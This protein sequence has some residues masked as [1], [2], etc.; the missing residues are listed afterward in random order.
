LD[1]GWEQA[2]TPGALSLI[3][4]NRIRIHTKRQGCESSFSAIFARFGTSLAH[5]P[6]G[7]KLPNRSI[8]FQSEL[9]RRPETTKGR[10]SRLPLVNQS[11]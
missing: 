8:K 3:I 9:F 4:N 2:G 5:G 1:R 11:N 6:N 7:R 10:A